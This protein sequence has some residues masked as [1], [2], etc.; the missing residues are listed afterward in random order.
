MQSPSGGPATWDRIWSH[1]QHAPV[2][3]DVI[4][5]ELDRVVRATG[6]STILDLGCGPA[7]QTITL[8]RKYNL[9]ATLVDYSRSG[10]ELAQKY[11]E[12][13]GLSASRIHCHEA[14]IFC[15]KTGNRFDIV[16]SGG[17]HEHFRGV[18]RQLAFDLMTNFARKKVIVVVPNKSSI[19]YWLHRI[20]LHLR[21][22]WKVGYEDPF[23]F[24]ELKTRMERSGL[25]QVSVKCLDWIL[26][27]GVLEGTFQGTLLCGEGTKRVNVT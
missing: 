13:L 19:P 11:A 23:L 3:R 1:C 18:E 7:R 22:D 9:E 8:A 16:Y 4:L 24:T 14:N 21:R 2:K 26:D 12:S 10:L 6:A 27:K 17:L 15:F 25:R 20:Y 5:R